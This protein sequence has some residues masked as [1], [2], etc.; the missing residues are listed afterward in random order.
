MSTL[1]KSTT[2]A[3]S[4]PR[5]TPTT[6]CIPPRSSSTFGQ[7]EGQ[8]CCWVGWTQ[9]LFVC[10]FTKEQWRRYDSFIRRRTVRLTPFSLASCQTCLLTT[11]CRR[12]HRALTEEARHV[13]LA[14][15][16]GKPSFQR[17]ALTLSRL[18]G[19]PKVESSLPFAVAALAS[20]RRLGSGV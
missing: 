5:H 8:P 11:R 2:S 10:R 12:D 13:T 14:D 20:S 18:I 16:C 7:S 6:S 15:A 19:R 17:L 9:A 1:C 3:S 4:F